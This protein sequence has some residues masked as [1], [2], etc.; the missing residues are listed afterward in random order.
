MTYSK[1]SKVVDQHCSTRFELFGSSKRA[2][3]CRSDGD[4]DV[5]PA[6]RS[7]WSVLSMLINRVDRRG[8]HCSTE[9][10][11]DVVAVSLVLLRAAC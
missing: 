3:R 11:V 2:L 9:E 5:L 6:A 10:A 8:G 7:F 1:Y 4:I